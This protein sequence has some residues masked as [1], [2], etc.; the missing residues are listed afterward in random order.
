MSRKDFVALAAAIA[1]VVDAAERKRMAEAIGA[2]CAA[3][4]PA[5]KWSLWNSACGVK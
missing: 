3:D 4:N 2:V 5:F 1:K